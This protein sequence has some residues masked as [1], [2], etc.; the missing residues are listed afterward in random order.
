MR[1]TVCGKDII[2]Q[3][4]GKG[5]LVKLWGTLRYRHNIMVSV[6]GKVATFAFHG[7]ENDRH[8]N[9]NV[10]PEEDLKW[11]LS[12]FIDDALCGLL[13]YKDFKAE[14]CVD[15]DTGAKK[16]YNDCK[17]LLGKIQ[18]LGIDEDLMYNMANEL[19]E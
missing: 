9:V 3:Q 19:S 1:I 12:S 8:N 17:R 5:K 4:R 2:V 11:A 18:A 7:S 15:E 16:M 6:G 14:C 13:T 10:L